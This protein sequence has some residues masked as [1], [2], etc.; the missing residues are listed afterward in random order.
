MR[1]LSFLEVSI[2][3]MLR[4]TVL[5]ALSA[6]YMEHLLRS[7]SPFALSPSEFKSVGIPHS[8]QPTCTLCKPH[9][10]IPRPPIHHTYPTNR[11]RF[12][13]VFPSPLWS[14]FFSPLPSSPC[15]PTLPVKTQFFTSPRERNDLGRREGSPGIS[16][17][18]PSDDAVAGERGGAGVGRGDGR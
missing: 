1:I 7:K 11:I 8:H 10:D 4:K 14:F 3:L 17:R 9:L 6:G 13:D 15:P 16:V 18:S 12:Y 2:V 5:S